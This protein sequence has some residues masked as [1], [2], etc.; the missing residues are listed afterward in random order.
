MSKIS[1]S[2]K[3]KSVNDNVIIMWIVIGFAFVVWLCTPPG[4]KFLQFCFW[5]SHTQ[6][7]IAKITNPGSV[8]EYKY[9][10]NNAVYLAKLYPNRKDALKEIDLAIG[11]APNFLTENEMNTL[12]K[13]RARIR[14]FLGEYEGALSD[15]IKSKDTGF[16]YEDTINMAILFKNAGDYRDAAKYCNKIL[17]IESTAYIGF[18]CL[19]DIYNTLGRSDV[20]LKVWDLAIDRKES[21]KFYLERAKIKKLLGDTVGY[22]EDMEVAKQRLGRFDEDESSISETTLHPKV[23]NLDIIK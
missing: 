15:Y 18:A 6:Y 23:L 20:A 21:G 12:Y 2:Q 9:H 14:L 13:E 3:K 1:I 19:A 8:K 5:G 17:N 11:T 7:A 16:N 22:N 4:N 10:R